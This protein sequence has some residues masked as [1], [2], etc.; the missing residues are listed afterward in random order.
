MNGMQLESFQGL[1]D[2]GKYFVAALVYLLIFCM[3]YC[4]VTPYDELK[5]VREGNV[6]PAISFGGALIGFVLPL[7]SAIT[8]SVGFLDMLVW[9]LVA[10]VVQILV[11]SGVRIIFRDLVRQIED[12][13]IAAASLLAFFSI[14]IGLL[15]AAS[16]TY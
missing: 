9:A 11:F 12:N 7:H 10:M 8:H 14:A 13:K 5:L 6:A 2:F 4:K 15:N 3:I 16:M 1:I